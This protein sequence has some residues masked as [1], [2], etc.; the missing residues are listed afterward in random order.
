MNKQKE[1]R[2]WELFSSICS[3]ALVIENGE[4]IKED[5]DPLN[6]PLVNFPQFPLIYPWLWWDPL[7]IQGAHH[8]EGWRWG[9]SMDTLQFHTCETAGD[10]IPSKNQKVDTPTP[11]LVRIRKRKEKLSRGQ[12]EDSGGDKRGCND[13]K[14]KQVAWERKSHM[15]GK[16][17]LYMRLYL[18]GDLYVIILFMINLC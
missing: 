4:R 15:K 2:A 7:T 1:F 6:F 18:G 14:R 10:P 3:V 17:F 13:W 8:F 9:G 16:K 12:N 5:P 11:K